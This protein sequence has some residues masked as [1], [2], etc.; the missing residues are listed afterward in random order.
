MLID[1]QNYWGDRE[2][3]YIGELCSK[4]IDGM[5]KNGTV[6]LFSKEP[7]DAKISGLYFL[8]DQLVAYHNWNKSDIIIDSNNCLE[9]HPEYTVKKDCV[10]VLMYGVAEFFDVLQPSH[11]VAHQNWNHEKTY[12]MFLGRANVTRLFGIQQHKK[13]KYADQGLVSWHHDTKAQLDDKVFIDFLTATGQTYEQMTDIQPFS[14]I[15]KIVAPPIT[16]ARDGQ[17]NWNSVYE[18]I[19]IELVFETSEHE[20]ALTMSEKI[21]RPMLYKRPF[22]LISGRHAIRNIKQHLVSDIFQKVDPGIEIRFF[23]N[24]IPL[25]YDKD[26][27][28]WRVEHVFDILGELIRSG[29]INTI[30]DDCKED[31]EINYQ[32]VKHLTSNLSIYQ[33]ATHLYPLDKNNWKKPIY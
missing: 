33:E 19:G 5:Q 12:G 11:T 31:L 21:L 6:T 15:G 1:L 9:S 8:L 17:V 22:M 25:D 4:I 18:K 29:K 2:M 23:E 30:V 28:I 16:R 3:Y 7:R 20:D 10:K 26:E 13:F 32:L 27:G 24:V 14:D